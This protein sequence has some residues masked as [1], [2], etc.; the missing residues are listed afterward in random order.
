MIGEKTSLSLYLDHISNANLC[1][2]NEGL[3]TAGVRLGFRF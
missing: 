2:N 3:E 1:D